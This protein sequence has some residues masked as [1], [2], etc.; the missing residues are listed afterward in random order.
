MINVIGI[1]WS[2]TISDDRKPVYEANMRILELYG[3]ERITFEEWL[4]KS[5]MTAEQLFINH[6]IIESTEKLF[7]LYK[8]YYTEITG[9]IEENEHKFYTEITR[10]NLPTIYPDVRYAFNHLKEKKKMIAV[11]SSHPQ[12]NLIEEAEEY[13]LT[14]YI[15]VLIGN[16]KDKVKGLKEISRILNEKLENI[17]YVGDTVFDIRDAKKAGCLSAAVFGLNGQ[18]G[19]HSRE[20]LLKEGP[21]FP[22]TSLYELCDLMI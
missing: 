6:G 1:D 13:G 7:D 15:S 18:R 10:P 3:K 9:L 11:L 19:Y 20:M 16:S 12:E 17:L 21:N 8:K 2:G 22:L 5:T 14:D 4:K